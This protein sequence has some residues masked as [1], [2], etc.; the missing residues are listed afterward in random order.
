MS[1]A[2]GRDCELQ[3]LQLQLDRRA[4]LQADTL[5]SDTNLGSMGGMI[6]GSNTIFV[7]FWIP[8]FSR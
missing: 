3:Q 7:E 8:Y 6:N 2:G 4:V 5:T 1:G